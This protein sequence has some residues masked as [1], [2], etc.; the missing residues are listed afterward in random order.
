M[1]DDHIINEQSATGWLRTELRGDIEGAK[2]LIHA[3]RKS[4]GA[5]RVINGVNE[6]I[7][8]G[9]PGGFFR[10]ML[11]GND[12]VT[13]EAITNNGNDT[14]RVFVPQKSSFTH[15]DAQTRHDQT[16]AT[17]VPVFGH[18]EP[19][20]TSTSYTPIT[21]SKKREEEE[22]EEEDKKIKNARYVFWIF[23]NDNDTIGF[24]TAHEWTI[25]DG[26]SGKSVRLEGDLITGRI[27]FEGNLWYGSQNGLSGNFKIIKQ[28]LN[29]GG[30]STI[31]TRRA[32]GETSIT[33]AS[34]VSRNGII[35]VF[36]NRDTIHCSA[37]AHAGQLDCT[38]SVLYIIRLSSSGSV[39][40]ESKQV[41]SITSNDEDQFST[42]SSAL[43][44]VNDG[45]TAY[46]NCLV[47][48][49]QSNAHYE[50][51]RLYSI[52]ILS[53]SLSYVT[54]SEK[55]LA[56]S[57]I[58]DKYLYTLISDESQCILV[59]RLLGKKDAD[60]LGS[61]P[62]SEH[63]ILGILD[64]DTPCFAFGD[65]DIGDDS[66]AISGSSPTM[67]GSSILPQENFVMF[68][69]G[70]GLVSYDPTTGNVESYPIGGDGYLIQYFPSEIFSTDPEDNQKEEW[71]YISRT[72]VNPYLAE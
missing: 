28:N 15:V 21:E 50:Q 7:A 6:R 13:I 4:L 32:Y 17:A 5:L 59:K 53:G 46:L 38:Q 37:G 12:G 10:R 2:G 40:S 1:S 29:G 56:S 19:T 31:Y 64:D 66:I 70:N 30:R 62:I 60:N 11:H 18:V 67:P 68:S 63:G 33:C 26:F 23:Y 3:A 47:T 22:E 41:I 51:S 48:G 55:K 20:S 71:E 65:V 72:N 27:I 58:S 45:D 61:L 52:D 39:I 57:V 16:S 9:E 36:F 44:L 49:Q 42:D 14:I 43:N 69:T 25:A 8:A 24:E 34:T 35:F 54:Y